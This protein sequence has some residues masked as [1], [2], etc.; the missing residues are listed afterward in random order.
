MSDI[1]LKRL[2]GNCCQSYFGVIVNHHHH[3]KEEEE[4]E[5]KETCELPLEYIGTALCY[6]P[7]SFL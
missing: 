5:G 3:H 4:K 1:P 2:N 7:S 6:S